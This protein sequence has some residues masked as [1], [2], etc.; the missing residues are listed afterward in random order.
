MTT[1]DKI[2]KLV[3]NYKYLCFVL[4][5][6]FLNQCVSRCSDNRKSKKAIT[7]LE[8]SMDSISRLNDSLILVVK[9]KESVIVEL[10]KENGILKATE[11]LSK[12]QIDEL[13]KMGNKATNI[14]ISTEKKD[15]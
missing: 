9:D 6:L 15:N 3:K 12:K 4:A 13:I 7:N 10:D 14:T 5:A 2:K 8:V 11:S 1:I